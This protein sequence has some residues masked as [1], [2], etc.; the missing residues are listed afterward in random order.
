MKSHSMKTSRQPSLIN[1][2][3]TTIMCNKSN[4]RISMAL[5]FAAM[6][7]TFTQLAGA[8]SYT[9]GQTGGG[10]WSTPGSWTTPA[11]PAGPLAGDFVTFGSATTN[12]T[13]I[14][15]NTVDSGFAGTVA[16]LNYASFDDGVHAGWNVTQIPL[17]KTLNVTGSLVCGGLN[18]VSGIH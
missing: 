10:N 18:A 8:A 2:L 15:N 16:I 13:P 17:G 12:G 4:V 7:I 1:T 6:F 9:W 5:A 14:V 3:L 11:N